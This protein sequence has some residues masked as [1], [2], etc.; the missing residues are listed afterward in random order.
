SDAGHAIGEDFTLALAA[1]LV[2][3]HRRGPV[4]T[5]LS[6]SRIVEDVAAG[7]G[8]ATIR[9]PVGGVNGAGRIRDERAAVGGE[10][11]GGGGLA[12]GVGR[13]FVGGGRGGGVPRCC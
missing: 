5:N 6:T 3:R 10:G 4:V 7:A 12:G 13:G 11:E 9:A 2:L 8:V 1:R